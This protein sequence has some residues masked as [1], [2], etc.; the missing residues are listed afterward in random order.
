MSCDVMKSSKAILSV[1]FLVLLLLNGCTQFL[2]GFYGY[3]EQDEKNA[4]VASLNVSKSKLYTTALIVLQEWGL[5][6]ESADKENGI[7][8][9]GWGPN[10]ALSWPYT[11]S[12]WKLTVVVVNA[13]GGTSNVSVTGT[14]KWSD[15]LGNQKSAPITRSIDTNETLGN[16]IQ[17]KNEIIKKAYSY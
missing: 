13:G 5:P 15:I 3:S 14:A 12:Y 9:T 6:I 4:R 10:K 1:G 16:L 11:E 7:I 8:V 17:I 2:N